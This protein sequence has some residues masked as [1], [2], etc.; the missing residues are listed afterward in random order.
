MSLVVV[1]LE[2][3]LLLP[4]QVQTY[5]LVVRIYVC[6]VH[7]YFHPLL[8]YHNQSAY[9]SHPSLHQIVYVLSSVRLIVSYCGMRTHHYL[10][11]VV[12]PKDLDKNDLPSPKEHQ[13][14]HSYRKHH[15]TL[16]LIHI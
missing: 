5:I 6:Y 2:R 9:R 13:Y 3:T 11:D 7:R 1:S 10:H 16:S 8:Y 15:P 14:N 12:Y 4:L